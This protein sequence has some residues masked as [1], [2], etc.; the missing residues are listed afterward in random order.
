MNVKDVKDVSTTRTSSTSSARSSA[1]SSNVDEDKEFTQ[2][3][4]EVKNTS[5]A[6]DKKAEEAKEADAK[7]TASTKANDKVETVIAK[8][9][10]NV[11]DPNL[12]KAMQNQLLLNQNQNQIKNNN[13]E[14]SNYDDVFNSKD[15]FKISMKSLSKDDIKF[16]NKVVKEPQQ[17]I[18]N[19]NNEKFNMN[20]LTATVTKEISG[21]NHTGFSKDL[22]NIIQKSYDAQKPVR[23]TIDDSSSVILKIDQQG[24]VSAQFLSNDMAVTQALKA[25]LPALRDRFD[26][27]GLPYNSLSYKDQSNQQQNNNKKEQGGK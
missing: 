8:T 5:E 3:L 6:Q 25:N 9:E 12:I 4:D 20:S 26:D 19:F 1:K 14:F 17:V 21:T 23:V 18:Q 24:K 7:K 22:L 11:I 15:A 16:L 10:E 2:A 27:E 13:H